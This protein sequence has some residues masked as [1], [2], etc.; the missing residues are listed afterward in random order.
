MEHM[1]TGKS[2]A[3]EPTRGH[4][5]TRERV[6]ATIGQV[7]GY[8]RPL[9]AV[10][11]L[12][13][14]LGELAELCEIASGSDVA[15]PSRRSTRDAEQLGSELADLWIIT[16]ALADQFLGAVAEPDLAGRLPE[17][18]TDQG[19]GGRP[20][21]EPLGGVVVAAGRIARI[22]NYYDGPKTPRAF[23]GWISLSETVA[24]FHRALADVACAHEVDLV[25]AVNTKLDAIPA[26]DSGRFGAGAHDPST[27]ASLERF[28]ALHAASTEPAAAGPGRDAAPADL[29]V[30]RARL[31]GSAEW[32]SESFASNVQAIVAH[33][34][35][36]TKAAP[37][38]RLD[39]YVISGPAFASLALLDN[40]LA[41]LL[42]AI[43]ARDPMDAHRTAPADVH[44]AAAPAEGSERCL[45]FNGLPLRV[46][47]FSPLYGA[48][49]SGRLADTFLL[50][51]RP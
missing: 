14:E 43:V 40:W 49:D 12:L 51:R 50:L 35:P 17:D 36:F 33:L 39:G 13:E 32:S 30:E 31:W 18:G 21:G 20:A 7:G 41:R 10:A 37:W 15:G 47:A 44:P 3:D 24:G 29:D 16:T 4:E 22:V 8:W 6:R 9:A 34:T 48:S 2:G 45:T 27:A 11:R 42:A 26:L 23:D 28:R 38:E 25:E 19:G 5:P 46:S 1:T